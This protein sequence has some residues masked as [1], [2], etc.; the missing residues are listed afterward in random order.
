[1]YRP[2][3]LVEAVW[4]IFVDKSVSVTSA[5]GIAALV[6]SVTI[7]VTELAVVAW[8]HRPRHDAKSATRSVATRTLIMSL[9]RFIPLPLKQTNSTQYD[10]K[11]TW[12]QKLNWRWIMSFM[13]CRRAQLVKA[14]LCQKVLRLEHQRS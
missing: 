5:P 4:A 7:P 14:I 10:C 8:P 12:A 2:D 13:L 1:M 3:S 6:E 11:P 9:L